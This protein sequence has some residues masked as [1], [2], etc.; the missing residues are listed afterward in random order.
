M[1]I[2]LLITLSDFKI[3]ARTTSAKKQ[4][5]QKNPSSQKD[6]NKKPKRK[7]KIYFEFHF[8]GRAK[9]ALFKTPDE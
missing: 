6:P 8:L 2:Y 5:P 9:S 7:L 1:L 3:P 4:Q